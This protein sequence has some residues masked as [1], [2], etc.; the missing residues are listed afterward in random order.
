MADKFNSTVGQTT[1]AS[2]AFLVSP[3]DT[4]DFLTDAGELVPRAIYVGVAGDL[5]VDMI[6]SGTVTFLN[7]PVGLYPLRVRKIYTT[8]TTASSMIALY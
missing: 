3:S 4:T 6:D 8:G 2:S 1:P 5:K 7:L